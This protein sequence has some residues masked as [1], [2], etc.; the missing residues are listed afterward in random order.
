MRPDSEQNSVNHENP[1]ADELQQPSEAGV[2]AQKPLEEVPAESLENELNTMKDNYLRLYA[3]FENYKKR[4]QKERAELIR[5]AGREVLE[6]LLPVLDDFER[7]IK[8]MGKDESNPLLE[9]VQLIHQKMNG[10]MEQQGVKAIHSI[11]KT[12]D[13]EQHEAITEMP[14][15]DAD[16][17]GKVIDEVEKGYMLNDKILRYAKVVIGR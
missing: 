15:E 1:I 10:I 3:E 17:K 7:A 9:G 14:V 8:A 16:Q 6:K 11:G 12:F 5:N 4:N 13:V 2:P